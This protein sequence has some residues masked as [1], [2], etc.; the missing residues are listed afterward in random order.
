MRLCK[1]KD[2]IYKPLTLAKYGT[3]DK[4]ICTC[5]SGPEKNWQVNDVIQCDKCC[6]WSHKMCMGFSQM[7]HENVR[8]ARFW[9]LACEPTRLIV[10]Y[11][12]KNMDD[13]TLLKLEILNEIFGLCKNK[14]Y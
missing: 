6:S 7:S 3:N 8:K 1:K 12:I 2:D 13:E 5:K 4:W 14:D 11:S 9:C 10:I